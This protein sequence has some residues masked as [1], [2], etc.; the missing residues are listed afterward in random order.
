MPMDRSRY[1][2]EWDAI[3]AAIRRRGGDRCE[4]CGKPNRALVYTLPGG[5]W[6]SVEGD[7]NWRTNTGEVSGFVYGQENDR[8]PIRVVRVILTT[9]HLGE[10]KADGSPG[11][12]HDKMDCR[13]SNLA[14]LC[15]ACHLGLDRGDHVLARAENRRKRQIERGQMPLPE[16][17]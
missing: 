17:G 11:D 7:G 6:C 13:P 3:S 8:A 15:Q 10:P 16:W 4:W 2:A 12:K 9:A 5:W 1:P 14:S